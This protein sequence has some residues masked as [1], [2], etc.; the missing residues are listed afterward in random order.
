MACSE[1]EGSMQATFPKLRL[2]TDTGV[3]LLNPDSPESYDQNQIEGWTIQNESKV[4][5]KIEIWPREIAAMDSSL[6]ILGVDLF[7]QGSIY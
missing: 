6:F 2:V 4:S 1:E 3:D 5:G 7:Y